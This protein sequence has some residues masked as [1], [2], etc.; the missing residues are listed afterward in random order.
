[1]RLR[2]AGVV[3]TDGPSRACR[4]SAACREATCR[5]AWGKEAPTPSEGCF[6]AGADERENV[7][8]NRH[9]GGGTPSAT[10]AGESLPLTLT[11]TLT[12][13]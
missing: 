12:Q 10:P 5:E 3:L 6:G 8:T 9:S 4:E 11:L 2:G 13:P 1:M 7:P